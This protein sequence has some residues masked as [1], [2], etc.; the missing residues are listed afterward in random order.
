ML[1]RPIRSDRGR[2]YYGRYTKNEQMIC[3]FAQFLEE[4]YIVA[5][6]TMFGTLK[7][8]GI[9]EKMNHTLMDMV[10]SILSNSQLPLFLWSE[11]L[12]TAMYILNRVP[13]KVV[14]KTLFELWNEWKPSLNH[15]R[16]WGCPAE[17]GIC[18]PN[19]K[20]LDPRTISGHFI[21]YVV[22]SK[23]FRFYC[24]SHSTRIVESINTK[25]L[26]DSEYNGS[27]YPQKIELKEAQELAEV[28]S[29]K[30]RLIVLKKI[31]IDYLEP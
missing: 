19:L 1:S 3:S 8:N 17:V 28:T 30:G 4:E 12:K 29:S 7:Q 10:R 5:Q 20:K 16:I 13:S 14:P 21:R 23:E 31:K 6:C 15:L 27:A 26:E 25:F 9:A 2:E 22:H 11:A 24:S 18:N